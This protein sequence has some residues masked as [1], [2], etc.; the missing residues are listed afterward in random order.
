[1]LF[2]SPVSG[3]NVIPDR[4]IYHDDVLPSYFSYTVINRI[5][6]LLCSITVQVAPCSYLTPK[7]TFINVIASFFL[8]LFT[9]N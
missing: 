3:L 8:A 2:T 6:Y 9:P 5:A 1:M 4:C 7:P